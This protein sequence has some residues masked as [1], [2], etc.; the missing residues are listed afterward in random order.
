MWG[1]SNLS[2]EARVGYLGRILSNLENSPHF[3]SVPS[4]RGLRVF[5]LAV[6]APMFAS[7]N[8]LNLSQ[9]PES[10][11]I[12]TKDLG[13]PR[14]RLETFGA[15]AVGS[16]FVRMAV[17]YDV[18]WRAHIQGQRSDG[19]WV[20]MPFQHLQAADG[21]NAWAVRVPSGVDLLR[22]TV[23]YGPQ[24][25]AS[26]GTAI[27]LLALLSLLAFEVL[28]RRARRQTAGPTSSPVQDL[29]LRDARNDELTSARPWQGNTT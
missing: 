5:K 3:V 27:S 14:Y 16:T 26:I 9:F 12:A 29:D 17:K 18:G 11:R 1:Y 22:G 2:G 13:G 23:V 15:D 6:T 7:P 24:S 20:A 10:Q 8:S 25:L 19:S 21:S 4:G 28:R